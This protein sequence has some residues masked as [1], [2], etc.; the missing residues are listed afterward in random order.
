MTIPYPEWAAEP[1]LSQVICGCTGEEFVFLISD[2]AGRLVC[3]RCQTV[4]GEWR[5]TSGPLVTFPDIEPMPPDLRGQLPRTVPPPDMLPPRD[6]LSPPRVGAGWGTPP[7][8]PPEPIPGPDDS[9]V[10][11]GKFDVPG[12]LPE[13]SPDKCNAVLKGGPLDGR[14]TYVPPDVTTYVIAGSGTYLR[15]LDVSGGRTVYL[16]RG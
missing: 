8:I 16:I 1:G 15:T 5:R 3:T 12:G 7:G 11:A 10:M 2:V 13:I 14:L 9:T 6:T 4:N